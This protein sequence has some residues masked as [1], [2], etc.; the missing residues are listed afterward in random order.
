MQDYTRFSHLEHDL[1]NAIQSRV[2]DVIRLAHLVLV[3]RVEHVGM[4]HHQ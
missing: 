3:I 2:L 1:G 4:Q